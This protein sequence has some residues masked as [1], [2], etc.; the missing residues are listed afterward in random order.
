MKALD[1]SPLDCGLL[2]AVV[3]LVRFLDSPADYRVLA[4]LVTREIVYRL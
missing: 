4:P 3:R 1:V 2:D